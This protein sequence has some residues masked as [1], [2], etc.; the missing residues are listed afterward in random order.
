MTDLTHTLKQYFGYDTFRPLQE[1]II[2]TALAGHDSLVLMP[3]GGGKSICFQLPALLLPGLTIVVSPLISLMKD[4]V[5]ALRANGI[6]AEAM[7][8][9]NDPHANEIIRERCV[10]GEIKLL[11]PKS[12]IRIS[13]CRTAKRNPL[14][15]PI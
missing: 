1:D 14:I 9:V 5:E 13:L 11:Y 10:K 6:K 3:T 2:R 8:S 12:V 4:Q 15:F 7:N